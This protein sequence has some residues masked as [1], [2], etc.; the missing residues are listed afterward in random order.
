MRRLIR[1][2]HTDEHGEWVARLDCGHNQHVRHK[3]P[4]QWREWVLDAE[5]RAARIGTA[6]ECPLCDAG[7]IPVDGGAVGGDPACLAHRVCP[8][9]DGVAGDGRGHKPGCPRAG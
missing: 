2:F 3:P 4:M 9:C 8:D 5:G 1:G 6:I 7:E